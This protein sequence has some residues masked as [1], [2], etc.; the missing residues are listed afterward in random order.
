MRSTIFNRK[1]PV[2]NE[3]LSIKPQHVSLLPVTKHATFRVRLAT[4]CPVLLRRIFDEPWSR[5]AGSRRSTLLRFDDSLWYARMQRICQVDRT[6]VRE[7][8]YDSLL[9][10]HRSQYLRHPQWNDIEVQS[11]TS[12]SQLSLQ[13]LAWLH[14]RSKLNWSIPSCFFVYAR[15]TSKDIPGPT[16]YDV[17]HAYEALN[18]Q[19]R[20]PPR[21]KQARQRHNQFLSASKR[22]FAGDVFS[23]TPGP[24]AYE[25]FITVRP[26]G[27]APVRDS[28]FHS[29]QTKQPG[30]ADYEVR[31][32]AHFRFSRNRALVSSYLRFWKI[33]FFAEHLMPLWTILL[34][35]NY[36]IGLYAKK[37][38]LI[39]LR[40]RVRKDELR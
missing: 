1:P 37:K 14:H 29:D 17:S 18:S 23:D 8:L 22:T 10:Q 36:K 15:C 6:Q 34:W 24:G 19:P 35:S 20:Q 30:P 16:A 7:N 5:M 3:I 28:R 39:L 4:I 25:G 38:P 31:E 40:Q 2:S 27:Y 26:H 12:H 21:S 33:R 11:G 32:D 9:L 13:Q